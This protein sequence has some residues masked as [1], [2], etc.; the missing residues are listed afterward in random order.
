MKTLV[1]I[2]LAVLIVVVVAAI[3][4]AG[5]LIYPGTP[6]HASSLIFQGYVPLPSDNVLSVLDYLTVKDDKLFVTSESTGDLYRI[7]IRKDSLPTAADVAKLQ[8]EPAAHGVVIDPSSHLGYVTRSEA[9][10]VDVFD[11]VK[12]I[13]IKRIPV[14]DGPD[15]IFYDE[16]NR[17]VYVASGDSHLATLI[18]PSTG[19]VL[20]TIPLGGAPEYAALDAGTKFLYQNLHDTNSVAVVDV[21]KR[22][23]AER[24]PLQGCEAPTGM[25]IDEIHRRLFI[26]CGANA[27]LAIFDLD[28]HRVITTVPIGM[29]PDSVVFDSTLRRIYTTGKAGVL[30]VIQQGEPT[31]YTI[32]DTVHLHYGA[33]TLTVDP[34]TH[35]LYVGYAS[36]VVNPRVAVFSPR[37]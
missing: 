20:A 18:D 27:V 9:N 17:L 14:A 4:V 30:I 6:S 37:I 16:I 21:V 26:G 24:W 28:G 36:V 2:L 7:Q 33:H 34:T 5:Y 19:T 8:G 29:A 15:A 3:A 32:L 1:N 35:T 10:T 11:P 25:A 23:V 12:M 13:V 22:T 31:K